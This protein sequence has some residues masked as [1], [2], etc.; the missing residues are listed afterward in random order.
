MTA[1]KMGAAI[2]VVQK[3][4]YLAQLMVAGDLFVLLG[5]EDFLAARVA[6]GDLTVARDF[7]ITAYTAFSP[8]RHQAT[9]QT[10]AA[11]VAPHGGLPALL[12]I[13]NLK[14]EATTIPQQ[15]RQIARQ[16]P[17]SAVRCWALHTLVEVWNEREP[18][19]LTPYLGDEAWLVAMQAGNLITEMAAPPID[20]LTRIAQ[21]PAYPRSHQLWALYILLRQGVEVDALLAAMPDIRVPL[22]PIVPS[23]VREA[24]VR[25]WHQAVGTK[26]DIRWLIEELQ[27]PPAP[28]YDFTG[29]LEKLAHELRANGVTV[30]EYIDNTHY[31]TQGNA[32]FGLI[33]VNDDRLYI[34]H[35]GPLVAFAAVGRSTDENGCY[36]YQCLTDIAGVDP[37]S[38]KRQL[39]ALCQYVATAVGYQWLDEALLTVEMP[40]YQTNYGQA[41]IQFLVFH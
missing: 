37:T 39:A 14:A 11:L 21:D 22:P 25:H 6:L 28:S 7:L 5:E 29:M 35:I 38:E 36:E 23:V 18:L 3:L 13:L 15:L 17:D 24:I 40:G 10:L 8:E 30:G 16:D 4:H 26:E 19:D 1:Q 32:S 9:Q 33:P 20:Q 27:L 12:A 34:S 2:P 31:R 41:S